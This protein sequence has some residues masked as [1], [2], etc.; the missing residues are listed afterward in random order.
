MSAV[1]VRIGGARF[2]VEFDRRAMR[3]A[4]ALVQRLPIEDTIIHARWSGPIYL[5][6]KTDLGVPLENPTAFVEA[7]DIVYHPTHFD[8]GVAYGATQFIE[9]TGPVNVTRLGR[10]VGDLQRLAAL[11]ESLPAH[12]AMPVVIST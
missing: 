8:V 11:G 9:M 2:D 10:L 6:R 4:A 3:T 7:G 1:S 5:L 12:G